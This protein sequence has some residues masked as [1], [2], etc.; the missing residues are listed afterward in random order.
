MFQLAFYIFIIMGAILHEYSHGFMAD[1]LGDPTA[2]FEGR[3]TFNPLKHIDLFGT[4]ILPLILI[5][6]TGIAFGYAKPVPYNPYNLKNPKRDAALVGAAGPLSNFLVAGLLGLVMR[7]LPFNT[8]TYV[9][10]I[11]L[12][13]NIILAVFNL[14]PI[15]PL[16]GSKVLLAF[17]PDSW[18]TYWENLERWGIFL[19]FIFIYYFFSLL[20]PIISFVFLLFSGR[21]LL[22]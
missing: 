21:P 5:L 20:M 1:K 11:G 13:V 15:P 16:D 22:M 12:L 17:I 2:R 19:V 14:V 4:I 3:L 18:A 10:G 8:F 6:T 7:F 9:L